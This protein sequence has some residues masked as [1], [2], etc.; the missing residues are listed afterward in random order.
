MCILYLL[1]GPCDAWRSPAQERTLSATLDLRADSAEAVDDE[2][3]GDSDRSQR[4]NEPT[5]MEMD[6]SDESQDS[7]RSTIVARRGLLYIVSFLL[8][9]GTS[10][11][12]GIT[13]SFNKRYDNASIFIL[14]FQGFWN[15]LI[16]SRRRSM[17]TRAGEM[18]K[19]LIWGILFTCPPCL[20][21]WSV[22]S[23]RSS[24]EDSRKG[25]DCETDDASEFQVG[26]RDTTPAWQPDVEED[27]LARS[28]T[29]KI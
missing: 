8:T 5:P 25:G 26:E 13:G 12:F 11:V 23:K 1:P 21:C 22:F 7:K 9:F 15:F 29:E 24:T 4:M 17:K 20:G 18:G 14:S 16:F 6:R 3:E 28:A 27:E 10:F 2:S 19:T